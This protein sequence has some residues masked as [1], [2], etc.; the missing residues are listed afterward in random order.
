MADPT[1][2]AKKDVTTCIGLNRCYRSGMKIIVADGEGICY[3][4]TGA[5]GGNLYTERNPPPDYIAAFTKNGQ[6]D[7]GFTVVDV[8]GDTLRLKHINRLGE[9]VDE[10]THTRHLTTRPATAVAG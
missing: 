9:V 2:H 8:S 5:G 3:V 7:F 4:V 6:D 10:W 1:A